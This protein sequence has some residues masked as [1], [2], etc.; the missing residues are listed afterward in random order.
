MKSKI[1]NEYLKLLKIDKPLENIEDIS[2]LIKQHIKTFAFSS[3]KV[4]LKE[5]IS[6]ELEDIYQNLVLK[7]RGGYCFE[8]NKLFYEVLKYLGFNVK[9]YLARVVNNSDI[10]V[11][12]THRFT[13][14]DLNDKKYIIDV[15][16]GF[17]T[18]SVPISFDKDIYSHAGYTYNI[19]KLDNE[20]YAMEKIKD[21]KPFIVT[22]FD[23]KRCY[24]SDF[25]MG[26]F[27]SHKHPCAV[28]VNNLVLSLIV[29]DEIRS[30]RNNRY[31]KIS[32][33]NVIEIDISSFEKFSKVLEEDFNLN[34]SKEEKNYMFIT[35]V[36]S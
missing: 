2:I 28:F 22:K 1:I 34:F 25:E 12:Q 13:L 16:V 14:L 21:L 20:N 29:G 11:P 31:V 23:L 24:E 9:F 6:L 26:H 30:L 8:H 7:K 32:T 3:A 33:N 5:D 4:V 18:P 35:Y 27:Y 10:E 15:G 17:N 36:K 19:K